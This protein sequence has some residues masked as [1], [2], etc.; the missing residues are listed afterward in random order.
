MNK[1][2]IISI[3]VLGAV[4]IFGGVLFK[5][6]SNEFIK[7]SNTIGRE[8]SIKNDKAHASYEEIPSLTVLKSESDLIV[9][10]IGTDTIENRDYKDVPVKVS[11]VKV[12]EVIKGDIKE[13]EI[14]ILQDA[15]L[16]ITP[17]KDEKLLMF[18]KKGTD[19]K[20][21]YIPV[22][23]GQGIYKIIENKKTNNRTLEAQSL[24]NENILNDLKGNYDD[25]RKS[26]K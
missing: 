4:V 14:K 10:I 12:S 18:L 8:L 25:L 5:I 26:L 16:D 2:K 21:C 20:D 23:G 7:D 22:G 15:D 1:K 6:K 3:F 11:T 9:E 13:N 17:K 19:N 24:Y